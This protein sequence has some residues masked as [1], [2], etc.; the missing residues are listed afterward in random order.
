MNS[1]YYSI[2]YLYETVDEA[3][4]ESKHIKIGY[5]KRIIPVQ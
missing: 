2:P 1:L 3:E 5:E 4:E